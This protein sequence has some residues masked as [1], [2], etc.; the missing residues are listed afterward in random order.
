MT[1]KQITQEQIVCKCYGKIN[2]GLDVLGTLPNGYH[3]VCMIMQTVGIYDTVTIKRCTEPGITVLSDTGKIPCDEHNLAYKAARAMML[4]HQFPDDRGIAIEIQKR[5]PIAAG[6]AGGSADCAGVLNGMNILGKC[7]L[8][9]TQL[10]ETGVKLGADVPYCLQGGTMLAE[11]LGEKLTQL[12]QPP[13]AFVLLAKPDMD[14][15]TK[16]VYDHLDLDVVDHP[17]IQGMILDLEKQDLPGLCTKMGNVLESVTATQF[18]VIGQIEKI[19]QDAGAL[20]AMMSGSGPTVFG[21]FTDRAQAENA[22]KKLQ[23]KKLA[24]QIYLTDFVRP[25]KEQIYEQ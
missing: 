23:E 14:V 5:I 19:M 9:D 7:N 18:P 20:H 13:Q 1:Q 3:E 15:S 25:R 24:P 2:L 8:T 16:Y 21:I 10:A 12:P 22:Q 11:G 4:E 6:M 17:D